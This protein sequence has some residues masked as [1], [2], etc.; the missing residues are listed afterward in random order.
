MT[1]NSLIAFAVI[2]ILGASGCPR[3]RQYEFTS[4][5]LQRGWNRLGDV[6]DALGGAPVPGAESAQDRAVVEPDVIRQNGSLLYVLNQYRGLTIVNLDTTSIVGHAPTYGFPRDLYVVG[7]RAYVLVAYAAQFEPDGPTVTYTIG[8]RLYVLDISNPTTPAITGQFDLDGDFLDSR[9]VGDVLY[10]VTADFQWYW[11]EGQIAKDQTSGTRIVSV[12]IADPANIFQADEVSLDG[13][14]SVVNATADAM[15]VAGYAGNFTDTRITY[16]DISDP[17]GAIAVRD[18]VD[19]PGLVADKFK[20]DAYQGVLRVISNAWDDVRKTFITTVDLSN[21]DTL[22]VLAQTDFE[23][24]RGEA[25]FAT[26]FDGPR[27]YVVTYLVIDPLFVIDLSDPADPKVAGELEV[28]G[29]ST[30]IEARGDQLIALG[31]DDTDGR[32]VCVSLFDVSDPALP[33][34]ADRVTFGDSWNWSSAYGDVKAFTVLDDTIL[35][36]FTG[37]E[38]VGGGFDRLQ[39]V[40]WTPSDLTLRGAVDVQGT[41][42]RSFQT[43]G[44]YFA[45]TSEEI[46]AIDATNPDQPAISARVTLAENIA[47]FVEINATLGAELITQYNSGETTVKPVSL[48]LKGAFGEVTVDVGQLV[49]AYS[50]GNG[51]VIVGSAWNEKPEY[52]V[53]LVDLTDPQNPEVTTQVAV[54]VQPYYGYW[55][56]LPYADV[57]AGPV[58]DAAAPDGFFA[59]WFPIHTQETTMVAGNTL[60]LRCIASSYDSVI[61]TET[62]YEG[63]AL[64]DLDTLT[65]TS[66]VGLGVDGVVSVD[67]RGN[68]I[69]ISSKTYVDQL[70]PQAT[71]AYY[72]T[73]FNPTTGVSGPTVNV[74]GAF[75]DYDAANEI[76]VLRDDQW[77]PDYSYESTLRTVVWAGDEAVEPIDS[78]SLPA[79]TSLLLGRDGRV[80]IEIY[81]NGT[82]LQCATVDAGGAIALQESALITDQW[83]SMINA[84]GTSAY[85][86][87]GNGAIA[88]YNCATQSPE[89]A[90]LV[91]VMGTPAHLR[92]GA[93]AVYAPLGYFGIV[94][95]G[96]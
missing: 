23:R 46:A 92:F 36:P 25:V 87:I 8:S 49:A 94:E 48:P 84:R 30:H 35:V 61:G 19:V 77:L 65:W 44:E 40:S 85:F 71:C 63:L 5:D 70:S 22:T 83:G 27:A 37:W 55:W 60:V 11:V 14:G 32:K 47:D 57:A 79:G 45:V 53:A 76:L 38:E 62:P 68:R 58:S 20:M 15:F 75:V 6:L 54:D 52:R 31:V 93:E 90:E 72:V 9:L 3:V 73:G 88:R 10:A 56:I 67:A 13:I 7:D 89:L 26:R 39:F 2:L 91:E 42:L 82:R 80:F 12:S 50:H 29:W 81:N 95:F 1:K 43:G 78:E 74:P 66:T 41:V 86:T 4:A 17:A 16:V 34:L 51:I 69:F 33:T 59:P 64:V 96:L 28:P 18:N 24:A 21:P